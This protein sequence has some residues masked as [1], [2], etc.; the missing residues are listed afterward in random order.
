MKW[1]IRRKILAGFGTGLLFTVCLSVISLYCMNSL[2]READALGRTWLP[3][4]SALGDAQSHFFATRINQFEY[5][6]ENDEQARAQIEQRLRSEIEQYAASMKKCEALIKQPEDRNIYYE[7][8]GEYSEFQKQNVQLIELI[9]QGKQGEAAQVL[10]VNLKNSRKSISGNYEKLIARI[11]QAGSASADHSAGVYSSGRN[12][13]MI[14][15]L[16]ALLL[17]IGFGLWLSARI[18]APVSEIAKTANRLAEDVLPKLSDSARAIAGGDLTKTVEVHF[19]PINLSS[20]DETGDM[21]SSFNLMIERLNEIARSFEQMSGKLQESVGR[22]GQSA[23]QVGATSAHINTVSLQSRESS[24]ALSS[25]TEQALATIQEMASSIRQVSANS[26][27]QSSAAT[28]TSAAIT[29]MVA[30]LQNIAEHARALSRLTSSTGEAAH[31]GQQTLASAADN[32]LRI[33]ASVE[34]VGQT[35]ASLGAR[36]ENIGRIVETID[37]IADQTNLLALNAAI[38][39]ARAGEHGLGFA[40]VA[41]EVRK[42]AERSARSTKEISE[43]I[44]TI[45]REARAAVQQMEQSDR[46]VRDYM[47]DTSVS[48]TFRTILSN[49]QNIVGRTQEIEAATGEQSAGAEQIARATQDLSRLT[50]EISS[51]AKEQA[52]GT[53]EVV[54]AMEQLRELVR[55]SAEMTTELQR[56]ADSLNTQSDVLSSVV[57]QFR[58][59]NVES[60]VPVGNSSD[61]DSL[62][63]LR[64]SGMIH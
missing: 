44:N 15:L 10:L 4:T 47:A 57:T 13:Q 7:M 17:S 22:I 64:T 51:A 24:T 26:Q 27:T 3:V 43:L 2:N 9:Q 23:L 48:D 39:A 1:T 55:Q 33:S 61:F 34:T 54:R 29:E 63:S 52:V 50:Q 45:Q 49:V 5:F 53:Q 42:L 20:S 25:S 21:A 31:S 30:S 18:S 38:E 37:D 41:D 12:I 16:L 32:V 28:E 62:S 58:T 11:G 8:M 46:I 59:D 19:E 14:A 6:L 60:T 36:A 40:V 56:S 35:I